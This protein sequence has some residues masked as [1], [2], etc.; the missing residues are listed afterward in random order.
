[1]FCGPR[2]SAWGISIYIEHVKL[3]EARRHCE[4]DLRPTVSGGIFW[5]LAGARRHPVGILTLQ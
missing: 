2:V 4:F 1:M 3:R 5:L